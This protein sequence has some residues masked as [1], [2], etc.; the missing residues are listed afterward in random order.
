MYF[1]R[2]SQLNRLKSLGRVPVL[3]VGAG[4]NGAGLFRDLCRQ[5]V[6]AVIVD[7]SDFCAGASA[8]PSRLIHGGLKYLETGELR[9]VA[10]STLE[11]NLLLRNA[12]HY[13]HPLPTAVPIHSWTGGIIPALRRLVTGK[14]KLADRGVLVIELGLLIY[15]ILSMRRQ[16][17]PRHKLLLRRR[18]LARFPHMDPNIVAIGT[19]YDAAI[20]MPERLG[21][22][23]LC[24]GLQDDPH[25]AALNHTPLEAAAGGTVT[26]RD[27]LSGERFSLAADIVVNAGGAWIDQINAALGINRRYIGGTKGS[28]LIV[29]YPELVRELDGQMIYFGTRDGRVC[30]LY[31]YLGHV[32]IGSTDI[33]TDDPDGAVCDDTEI[34]YMLRAVAEIFP[35]LP[36]ARER[37][38]YT[39][40]GV[41]PLPAA[42]AEN[43]G[44]ISRDHSIRTDLL[45]GTQVPVLSLIG[46]KWTTFRGFAEEA[47]DEV[48]RRLGKSRQSSTRDLAIGGGVGFPRDEA[49]RRAFLDEL[50]GLSVAPDRAAILLARYG[51][52]CRDAA[53]HCAAAPDAPLA[54]L[55][56]FSSREIDWICRA[57]LVGSLAD[58][59]FRRTAIAISGRLTDE[60][61]EEVSHRAAAALGWDEARRFAE[62]AAALDIA[63]RRHAS[64]AVALHAKPPECNKKVPL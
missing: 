9:L 24:D 64:R 3:I 60:A 14:G 58:I 55:P 41:R 5:G 62:V 44:E 18:A 4:I 59:L 15:D 36:V 53:A 49:A 56:D 52:R 57:E 54:A 10:Q 47:A 8:A 31:P 48:L 32:L 16:A 34:D 13:V 51:T 28:H 35:T 46:G 21:L 2:A 20:T 50:C 38:L 27:A 19:Y 6:P 42:D 29:D 22:E 33:R 61:A 25:A 63:H 12:P 7:K 1:E 39:Y 37:I 11:R 30:L 17:M 23:L 45:P 26:L 43:P 40:C